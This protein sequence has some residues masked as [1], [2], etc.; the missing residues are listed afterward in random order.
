M[1]FCFVFASDK[2]EEI[3]SLYY[4]NDLL[5]AK[6]RY[7]LTD[8][9]TSE[10]YYLGYNIYLKLDDLNKANEALQLA[11]DNDENDIQEY[12]DGADFLSELINDLKNSNKTL[13]SGFIS[14]SIDELNML[15]SKYKN[16][17]IVYYRLGHAY[18]AND[19]Y[20]NAVLNFNQA[21]I[22]NPYKKE[23]K[24]EISTI[25]NIEILKGKQ[26]YDRKEYQDALIHFNKAL[27]YD[28]ENS[29]AMF[30]L[31]NI[32]YVIRDYVKAAELFEKGT[33]YQSSN[34]KI[35]YMLGRCYTA[36]SDNDKA[37]EAY[38]KSLSIKP[39]YE[40][41]LFEK[42]KIYKILGEIEKS[43]DI[44]NIIINNSND[45]KSYELFLDIEI[46]QNNLSRAMEIGEKAM[47]YNPE[48]HS[49]LARMAGLYN[50]MQNFDKAKEVS[51]KSIKIKRNYAPAAF[52]LGVAEINLCN[53]LA[54]K[55]AFSIAKRDRNYRKV[56]SSYLK[57][58]NFDY[59]TKHCN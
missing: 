38:D 21:V 16:N 1:L 19:D 57:Q 2:I 32:Y 31:G 17:A 11:I 20:D 29:S 39:D 44:L 34:Y 3:E 4:A 49:L 33:L 10:V 25:A 6:Q 55:E 47:L 24:D 13:T 41:S 23:Y 7:E 48:S 56:A 27:E 30:R 35:F 52:E 12:S 8:H 28:P 45:S 15:V 54:A 51:K 26:Y 43:K 37:L 50:E 46:E 40:K 53:K 14:E 59:Y 9:K 36:L 58:E 18:K 22:L 42:A 5:S